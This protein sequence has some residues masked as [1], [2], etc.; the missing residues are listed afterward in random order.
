LGHHKVHRIL[1]MKEEFDIWAVTKL[2]DDS[3]KRSGMKPY[4]DIQLALDD[5]IDVVISRGMEPNVL[6]MPSGGVTVPVLID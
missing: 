5:A 1:K 2:D 3:I 6:I 4:G